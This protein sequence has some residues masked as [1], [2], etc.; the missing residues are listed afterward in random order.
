[1]AGDFEAAE[2]TLSIP[3]VW[4][5]P[6]FD[7]WEANTKTPCFSRWGRK[8]KNPRLLYLSSLSLPP[9]TQQPWCSQLCFLWLDT[10]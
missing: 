9:V 4:Q 5:A 7:Y 3:E 6:L 10:A 2:D 8:H 1:M